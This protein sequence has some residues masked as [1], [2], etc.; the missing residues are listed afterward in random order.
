VSVA[1]AP[2]CHAPSRPIQPGSNNLIAPPPRPQA[3]CTAP[4]GFVRV[5]RCA[6]AVGGGFRAPDGVVLCHNHLA[7]RGEVAAAL[8]HELLHAYDHCRAA[9]LDWTDCRHH[10]CSEVRAASL[11]GDCSFK[12]EAMRGHWALGGQHQACVKRR[13]ELSVAMNPHCGGGRARAAVEAAF[14]DCFADTA[15]FDRRP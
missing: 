14:K 12:N 5:E 10:A 1:A 4:P 15:P 8:A 11:S 2:P 7:S 3:G 9:D 6:A 13:A